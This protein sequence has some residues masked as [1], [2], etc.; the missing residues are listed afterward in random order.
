MVKTVAAN[1]QCSRET[2]LKSVKWLVRHH[3]K[4]ILLPKWIPTSLHIGITARPTMLSPLP[5]IQSSLTCRQKI[6]IRMLFIDFSS[7]NIIAAA[8][9][10]VSPVGIKHL[11]VKV[12]AKLADRDQHDCTPKSSTNT[13]IKSASNT[14]VDSCV[15]YSLFCLFFWGG[16]W[17]DK[18]FESQLTGRESV[19]ST[20]G[21]LTDWLINSIRHL[22]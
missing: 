16:W 10:Q 5:S 15:A 20:A 9:P 2:M 13:F 19:R 17:A 4:Y 21:S 3:I 14:T 11:P 6:H 8:H 7:T 1:G 12:A 18:V 22:M